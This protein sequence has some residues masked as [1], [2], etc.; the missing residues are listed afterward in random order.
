MHPYA[1][2]FMDFRMCS[3]G[4]RNIDPPAKVYNTRLHKKIENEERTRFE[5]HYQN[6]LDDV[7]LR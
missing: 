6:E 1:V 7:W 3:T 2:V 4:I 5:V